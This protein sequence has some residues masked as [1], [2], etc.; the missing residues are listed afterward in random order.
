MTNKSVSSDSWEGDGLFMKLEN[1][2]GQ[3]SEYHLKVLTQQHLEQNP[4]VEPYLMDLW[5]WVVSGTIRFI[6]C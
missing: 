5:A 6:R 3:H 4:V 1:P 2:I